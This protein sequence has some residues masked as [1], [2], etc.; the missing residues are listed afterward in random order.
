MD[1]KAMF[2]FSYGLYVVSANDG[3]NVGACLINTALQVTGDPLQVAVTLNKQN[4]T[5]QVVK[6]AEHFTLT[7]VSKTAD[8]PFI[9]RFGFKSSADVDKFEGITTKTSLLFDPY[10]PEHACAMVCCAVVNTIDLGTHVM[11]IGE[12]C[13]AE[14]VSD[15]EPMTYAYY[16]QVKGGK[17]PPKASSF[18]PDAADA[19]LPADAPAEAAAEPGRPKVAWRCTVCGH[20]VYEDELPDDFACPVCG[21]GKDMFERVEL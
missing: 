16:H 12:V 7:V 3:E 6:A 17:T 14:R 8:M 2:S 4:H 1:A 9:G 5:T 15:E 10:T 19:P 18:L 21:V 11:F 13:D 20:M